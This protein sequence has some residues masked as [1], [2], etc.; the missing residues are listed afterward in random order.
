MAFALARAYRYRR[1][2]DD[3]GQSL[4]YG[5]GRTLVRH[6]D[7]VFPGTIARSERNGGAR[8]ESGSRSRPG[9]TAIASDTEVR[10]RP[11]GR[12]LHF[13]RTVHALSAVCAYPR[14]VGHVPSS[15]VG[16]GIPS[17]FAVR[18]HP[19]SGG[20]DTGSRAVGKAVRKNPRTAE[21]MQ[22]FSRSERMDA[23]IPRVVVDLDILVRS[24]AEES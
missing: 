23:E 15:A 22:I 11:N 2:R 19:A 12:S 18:S 20:I 4:V 10:I 1:S 24:C 9:R 13:A 7:R 3:Y 17:G 6:D 8:S 16:L 14:A 5:A 21:N